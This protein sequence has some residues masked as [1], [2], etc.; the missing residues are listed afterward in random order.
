MDQLQLAEQRR[1]LCLSNSKV[2]AVAAE[3]TGGKGSSLAILNTI[4]DVTVP[5]F[6]VV[7]TNA[8][9]DHFEKSEGAK[10]DLEQLQK[11]SDKYWQAQ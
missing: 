4:K 5:Q 11:L 1:S 6:F 9:R 10:E 3:L 8:F 7:T 2:Q